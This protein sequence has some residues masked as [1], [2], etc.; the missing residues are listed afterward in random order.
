MFRGHAA[1]TRLRWLQS[2]GPGHRALLPLKLIIAPENLCTGSRQG[3]L[4]LVTQGTWGTV[5][6]S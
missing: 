1:T 2:L 6:E 5:G 3:H 4:S